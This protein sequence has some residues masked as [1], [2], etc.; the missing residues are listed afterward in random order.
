ME[1]GQFV[2]FDESVVRRCHQ[3][4]KSFCFHL[5]C[6]LASRGKD[7]RDLALSWVIIFSLFSHFHLFMQILRANFVRMTTPLYV[8]V[9]VFISS[10][11]N[12][13]CMFNKE[14]KSSTNKLG[15][16]QGLRE[17]PAAMF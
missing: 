9:L 15:L 10:K 11:T 14:A 1:G 2:Y 13:N 8:I 7:C 6:D 5:K 3:V 16:E 17:G 4:E 12:L